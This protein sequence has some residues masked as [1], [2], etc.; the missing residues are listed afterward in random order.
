MYLKNRLLII[1]ILLASAFTIVSCSSCKVYKFTDA[2]V[3]PRVK[4]IKVELI[5]NRA[6]IQNSQISPKLTDNLRQKIVRQT[7]LTQVSGDSVDLHVT[8]FITDYSFSTSGISNQQVSTNRLN[9]TV[10]ITVNNMLDNKVDEYDVTRGFD[11]ASNISI[12]QAEIALMD[13]IIR[14]LTDDIFNR[15]FSNW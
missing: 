4:T 7:R 2:A 13:E 6:R 8:G 1:S 15:I 10:H 9:I 14:S 12:S 5:E 11:F 3:D